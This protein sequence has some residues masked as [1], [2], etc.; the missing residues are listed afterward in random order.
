MR[1]VNKV[2]FDWGFLWLVVSGVLVFLII[3]GVVVGV[4]WFRRARKA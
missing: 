1:F 2:A 4:Y 3:V